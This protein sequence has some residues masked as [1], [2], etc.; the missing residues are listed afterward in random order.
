MGDLL[1]ALVIDKVAPGIVDKKL[2]KI[3]RNRLVH[4]KADARLGDEF[5]QG[6]LPI[7]HVLPTSRS[8]SSAR[9]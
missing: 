7:C 8:V 1:G 5:G 2:I 3:G 6:L 4:V 9:R